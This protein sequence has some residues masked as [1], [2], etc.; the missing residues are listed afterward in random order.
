MDIQEKGLAPLATRSNKY[1]RRASADEGSVMMTLCK[2]ECISLRNKGMG[3]F[4]STGYVPSWCR[5]LCI[6]LP[7]TCCVFPFRSDTLVASCAWLV[8]IGRILHDP[9]KILN[10]SGCTPKGWQKT[11]HPRDTTSTRRSQDSL[12]TCSAQRQV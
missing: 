10:N 7:D 5:M 1:H 9:G 11:T 4:A 3:R 2:F 8:E 12:V 6:T